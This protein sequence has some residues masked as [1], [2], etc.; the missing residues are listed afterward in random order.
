MTVSDIIEHYDLAPHPE[1]GFYRRTYA[2]PI[3]TDYRGGYR[4]VCTAI[5]F[6][7]KAGQY[8]R[9]HR[10]PQDEMWHFYL[11]DPLRLAMIEP[12]GESREVLLGQNILAGQIVQFS[13][14]AG[15][16]FGAAP[17]KNSAYCLVGCTVAP[18]FRMD[19][20][21]L[22]EGNDLLAL[23]PSARHVIEEFCPSHVKVNTSV[24]STPP[25]SCI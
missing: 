18:G 14:P 12:N 20:L 22:G 1:G 11:G 2:S 8:S 6:L 9:L 17:A 24:T 16:W 15:S 25:K 7:L 10:I 19:E 23:F 5:L 4:P 3:T 21:E 13:V